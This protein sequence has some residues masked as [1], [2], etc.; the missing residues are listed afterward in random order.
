[1]PHA[2][3][4]SRTPVNTA[5]VSIVV[6][7]YNSSTRLHIPLESLTRQ[8]V[9]D[10][11]FEVIVVD[12]AST[13]DTRAAAL[14]HPAVAWMAQHQVG[15]KIVREDRQGL[16]HARIRGVLEASGEIVGFLDDDNAADVGYVRE[17]IAAFA[18]PKVGLVVSRARP[19]YEADSVPPSIARRAH[20]LAVNEYMGDVP[21]VWGPDV[22]L[23]PSQGA[24]MWVRRSVFLAAVPWRTPQVLMPDRTGERMV[25]G[26][27]I[28]LGILVGRAGFNR[29][30]LPQATLAHYV[31]KSRLHARYFTRLIVG[32]V[33]S[34]LTVTIRY[35]LARFSRW[36]RLAALMKLASAVLLTPWILTRSDGLREAAFVLASRVAR[37]LGPYPS[38][39]S[40]S[41]SCERHQLQT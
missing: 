14:K 12:N 20:L 33:R 40:T 24:G 22:P 16:T 5:K 31:P 36:Q 29:V 25:S 27:D 15:F 28:E 8:D 13:D 18:D 2:G 4:C 39:T 23:V 3:S 17:V 1:M 7:C 35:S 38:K 32:I 9:P 21:V 11:T 37:V 30:Y 26:G 6:P 34:E 41:D 10:G 19:E